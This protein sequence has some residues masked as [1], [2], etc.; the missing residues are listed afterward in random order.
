MNLK[1]AALAATL[2]LVLAACG[3]DGAGAAAV[4]AQLVQKITRDMPEAEVRKLLGEPREVQA[5]KVGGEHVSDTWYYGSGDQQ[6][7]VVV[8]KGK[9]EGAYIGTKPVFEVD[10][11]AGLEP[12]ANDA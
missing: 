2:A 7:M 4:D 5:L 9:V 6:V 1:T 12:E 10:S 8:V 3:G 11:D